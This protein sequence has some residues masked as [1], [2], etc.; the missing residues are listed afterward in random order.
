M[1]LDR[2]RFF[3]GL[4][5]IARKFKEVQGVIGGRGFVPD[6]NIQARSPAAVAGEKRS[7]KVL[8]HPR[9]GG[10]TAADLGARDTGAMS[11]GERASMQRQLADSRHAELEMQSKLTGVPV[12]AFQIRR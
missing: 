10:S 2:G 5:D 9:I 4:K 7:A 6:I 11:A 1:A 8:T 3:S 12:G